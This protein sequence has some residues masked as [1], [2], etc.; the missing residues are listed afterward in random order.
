MPS[1]PGS[2]RLYGL[3]NDRPHGVAEKPALRDTPGT[4]TGSLS[5][6]ECTPTFQTPQLYVASLV[7]ALFGLAW[8]GVGPLVS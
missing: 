3:L 5:N 1:T 7:V 2:L 4:P 8:L 6:L